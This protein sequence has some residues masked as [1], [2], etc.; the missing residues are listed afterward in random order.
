MI[1]YRRDGLKNYLKN[2]WIIKV[3]NENMSDEEKEIR[4]NKWLSEM[5]NK[6]M[7]YA[8]VYGDILRGEQRN[9][10]VLDVGGESTL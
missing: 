6:R 4:T 5:D 7:I 1:T 9:A 3:L 10:R 8:D 2:D